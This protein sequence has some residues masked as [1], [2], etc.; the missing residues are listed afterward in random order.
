MESAS[1]PRYGPR[2]AT[3]AKLIDPF[4]EVIDAWLRAEPL[5]WASTI[6]ER[7]CEQPYGFSGHYQR[8]KEYVAQRRPEIMA[9]MGVDPPGRGFHR[10]FEVLPGAQAQVDWG[11]EHAIVTDEGHEIAVY[12]FHMTLSYPRDP[13]CRFTTSQDLGTF[14]A[15]HGAAFEHFGGVPAAV[16]YDRIKTV[17]RRHVGR[18]EDTPLHP[19]ALAFA[20]HYGFAIR[21]CRPQR[22]QTKGRVERAVAIIRNRVLAGRTFTCTEEMDAAFEQWL[23]GWRARVHR[24]YHEVLAE[25]A[26]RDRGAL[27]PL[28]PS[29]YVVADRHIRTV[30]KDAL[31]AFETS[32]YSVPWRLVRPRQRIELRVTPTTVAV[33][34]LGCE[35]LELAVHAR[36]QQRGSWVIDETHWDGLPDG[37]QPH[38][39]PTTATAPWPTVEVARRPLATYDRLQPELPL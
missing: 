24:S 27:Q 36:A 14:W 25:R 26:A 9:E 11:H 23:P 28:P 10:R 5:L 35:P 20:A 37:S 17:V 13:F 19:E 2:R 12:S 31:V 22:P 18:G 16:L 21:L 4:R 29:A 7:L 1:P 3:R 8:V 30:G 39:G 34:T 32:L 33:W 6:H 38:A 15:C